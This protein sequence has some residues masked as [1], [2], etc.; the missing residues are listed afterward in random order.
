MSMK[1]ILYAF[2]LSLIL[3]FFSFP[4]VHAAELAYQ[5]VPKAGT[6]TN[7]NQLRPK[8]SDDVFLMNPL[9]GVDCSR[10]KGNCLSAFLLNILDIVITLGSIVVVLMLVFVGFKFV[11]AQGKPGEVEAARG[12]L[13]WT[14]VG[15]LILLGAKA[16]A[17]GVE[18]TV[19]A[20][21]G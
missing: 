6:E 13:L 19:K 18:A 9:K 10:G 2:P 12:M 16:I 20:L 17:M 21:G 7:T 1:N 11:A 4:V 15:A 3:V 5:L 8:T 14:L